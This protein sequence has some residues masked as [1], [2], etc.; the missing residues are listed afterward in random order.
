M[1]PSPRLALLAGV[2][3]CA[4]LLVGPLASAA[5]IVVLVGAAV[6]DALVARRAPTA[7]RS[8]PPT[9]SRGVPAPL[10][11]VLGAAPGLRVDVRQPS[12]AD[13]R[14]ERPQAR[15]GLDTT[16]RAARR[17]R[18]TLPAV[19]LRVTGPLRLGRADHRAAGAAQVRVY[20]D[21]VTARRLA[22]AVREDRRRD[23]GLRARGPLGLG[24]EF[25]RVRD[26]VPD[27]DIRQ[28]NWRATARTGRPMSNEHR[29]ETERD[30][31]LCVDAGRLMGAPI[32][33][34][35]RLDCALDAAAAV[36]Y[37]AD[38][39]ADRCGA[40][41]YDDRILRRVIPGR[42]SGR[43][44]VEAIYDVEP[45]RRDAD[46]EAAFALL[47]RGKRAFVLVLSD[48]IE[49]TAARPLLSALPALTR[50]HAVVVASPRDREIEALVATA[51]GDERA[52]LVQVAALDVLAARDRV[53]A[54][55]R[56]TG[57]LV[58]LAPADRLAATCVQAYLRLK[59]RGRF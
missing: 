48:L 41:A 35:T 32:G 25:E 19:A 7:Q 30:V 6:A 37:V 22:L 36:A 50:A 3:A 52:A 2:A 17:G 29:V 39:L 33:D 38:E 42:T 26:Y 23:P 57:A 5:A 44:V 27:D 31:L 46:P 53:A 4:A 12:T 15:G 16:L 56:A 43:D 40:I 8:A 9:L 14:A 21:L 28:V 45:S 10:R 24:T 47:G 55:V 11:V 13:L 20:P 34:R 51:P 58:V 54:R 59:A 1:S 18:H 49:E